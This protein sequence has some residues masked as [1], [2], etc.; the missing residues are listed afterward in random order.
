M[1]GQGILLRMPNTAEDAAAMRARDTEVWRAR[2]ADQVAAAVAEVDADLVRAARQRATI[3]RAEL[4]G[5]R[6][7]IRLVEAVAMAAGLPSLGEV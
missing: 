3:E 4:A 2:I 7:H 1:H 6:G 5:S